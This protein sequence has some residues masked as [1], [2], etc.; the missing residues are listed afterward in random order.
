M[1]GYVELFGWATF[2]IAALLIW[3]SCL[4]LSHWKD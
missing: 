3:L 2:C 4:W 1:A